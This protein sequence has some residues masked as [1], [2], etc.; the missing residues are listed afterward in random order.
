M[1]SG[2][3]TALEWLGQQQYARDVRV[4]DKRRGPLPDDL[5]QLA[6]VASLQ[7]A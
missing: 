3:V 4:L 1:C 2:D 5:K 7:V 6:E